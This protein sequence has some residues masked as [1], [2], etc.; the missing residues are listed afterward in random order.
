MKQKFTVKK[1]FFR[2]KNERFRPS[3]RKNP[4]L[5]RRSVSSKIRSLRN[6]LYT[7][8][9]KLDLFVAIAT[10]NLQFNQFQHRNSYGEDY[11]GVH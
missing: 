5:A 9:E 6:I 10:V 2:Q 3:A 4:A 8:F 11:Y 7:V 1:N